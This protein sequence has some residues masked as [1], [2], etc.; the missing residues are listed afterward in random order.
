M[1]FFEGL[2]EDFCKPEVGTGFATNKIHKNT[3][4][5][6]F[7]GTLFPNMLNFEDFE[8]P[9]NSTSFF[10]AC[11]FYRL[12]P[13]ILRGCWS[14]PTLP[15]AAPDAEHPVDVG[16][17]FSDWVF[18]WFSTVDEVLCYHGHPWL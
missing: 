14:G 17:G 9:K 18:L 15:G 4:S 11:D 12:P 1:S 13:G 8:P 10:G 2:C 3:N 5:K 6:I 16:G 7:L